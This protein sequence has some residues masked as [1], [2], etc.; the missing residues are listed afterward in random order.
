MATP[1]RPSRRKLEPVDPVQPKPKPQPQAEPQPEPQPSPA[2]P[3]AAPGTQ[4]EEPQ[5]QNTGDNS[6]EEVSLS[7]GDSDDSWDEGLD[8]KFREGRKKEQK[9]KEKKKEKKL[10]RKNKK[11]DEEVKDEEVGA[12]AK[13]GRGNTF[14]VLAQQAGIQMSND[15]KEAE[16]VLKKYGCEPQEVHLHVEGWLTFVYQEFESQS[17]HIKL[18]LYK[19]WAAKQLRGQQADAGLRQKDLLNNITALEAFRKEGFSIMVDRLK[20]HIKEGDGGFLEVKK[21][22]LREEIANFICSLRETTDSISSIFSYR[23]EGTNLQNQTHLQSVEQNVRFLLHEAKLNEKRL[24]TIVIIGLEKAGKSTFINA[25]LEIDLL[26]MALERCTQVRTVVRPGSSLKVV[27]VFCN[28]EE[29]KSRLATMLPRKGEAAEAFERRKEQAEVS[30]RQLVGSP[31]KIFDGP[32]VQNIK[33]EIRRYVADEAMMAVV[34]EVIVTTDKFPPDVDWELFDVPGFDSPIQEHREEALRS[35][36]EAD[37]FL[38]LSSGERPSFTRE[39]KAFLQNITSVNYD[40]M[41][42]AFGVITK[43]D[44]FHSEH[45]FSQALKLAKKEFS[46]NGFL[47]GNIFPVCAKQHLLSCVGTNDTEM[48]RELD[49]RCERYRLNGGFEDCT[50]AIKY[51][52]QHELPVKRQKQ[53]VEIGERIYDLATSAIAYGRSIIPDYIVKPDNL[54]K[55][56]E[57]KN[58]EQWGHIF[59]KERF[60]PTMARALKWK[61]KRMIFQGDEH[62]QFYLKVFTEALEAELRSIDLETRPLE[63]E[64]L[65]DDN[66]LTGMQVD[67]HPREVRQREQLSQKL[68]ACV[69]RVAQKLAHEIYNDSIVQFVKVF[70]ETICPEDPHIF[71]TTLKEDSCRLE[72]LSLLKRVAVP[73]V[74]A[75]LK[76]PHDFTEPR[77]NAILN[78]TR[79]VPWV[80]MKVCVKERATPFFT[81][82]VSNVLGF[83]TM[84]NKDGMDSLPKPF[85]KL[86]EKVQ[87]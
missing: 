44:T 28:S 50:Y 36:L 68:L 48:K 17:E 77:R 63:E 70:N 32:N 46:D 21:D 57:V 25:I 87:V 66:N 9:K 72:L 11:G 30:C 79:A 52:V 71:N 81:K 2:D 42:K 41:S 15:L 27:V 40:A 31:D 82:N 33:E 12:T 75:I 35:I 20:D 19:K 67:H 80:A 8:E 7:E 55:E 51:C 1:Q 6:D 39:Q 38:I 74:W 69:E 26:P 45:E 78:L 85:I 10:R 56:L 34:K 62:C 5:K 76:W 49:D 59:Q 83:T 61:H 23:R 54:D 3:P 65:S 86:M 24:F 58:A 60:S 14:V 47:D 16:L 13:S 43:L 18:V 64:M 37:A 22:E 29:F 53:V 73:L 4:P 84:F